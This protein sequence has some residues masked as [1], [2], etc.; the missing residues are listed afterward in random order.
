MT[1]NRTFLLN[2]G[3]LTL[4]SFIIINSLVI[5]FEGNK[6]VIEGYN[7]DNLDNLPSQSS[8]I[9]GKISIAGNSGWSTFKNLGNCTGEGTSA[10]PYVIEN[11][12][13]DGGFSGSCILIQNSDVF[14]RIENCIVFNSDDFTGAG[15]KLVH[16]QNAILFGNNF[17]DNGYGIL[18]VSSNNNEIINNVV[19][20][21]W[22]GGMILEN[23]HSN[24]IQR[25]N[26]DHNLARGMELKYSNY[27]QILGNSISGHDQTGLYLYGSNYNMIIGNIANLNFGVGSCLTESNYNLVMFN[28]ALL[29]FNT[30]DFFDSGCINVNFLNVGNPYLFSYILSIII[31]FYFR[32]KRKNNQIISENRRNM[33]KLQ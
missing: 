26:V 19:T 12:E 20:H 16:V 3:I 13:I 21:N 14:F 31:L 4:F 8:V 9:S 1:K 11:L 24:L 28:I 23:S 7:S 2:L 22:W 18:L 27:N 29:N 17:T 33:E 32:R 25:N 5:S 6:N 15:I 10:D 30:V